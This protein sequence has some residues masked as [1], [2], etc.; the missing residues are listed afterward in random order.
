MGL[1]AHITGSTKHDP[2]IENRDSR[3]T[4]IEQPLHKH[5]SIH[6]LSSTHVKR[7]RKGKTVLET[8][9]NFRFDSAA[10]A[11]EYFDLNYFDI[12]QY[13]EY[14]QKGVVINVAAKQRIESRDLCFV[15]EDATE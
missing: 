12:R 1:P 5:N 14:K 13:C 6:S 4:D 9:N 8:T 15:Y 3:I 10:H 7:N 2:C 11:A